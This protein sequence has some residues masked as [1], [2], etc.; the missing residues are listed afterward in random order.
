MAAYG[1]RAT[2]NVF[3]ACGLSAATIVALTVLTV[4]KAV[5]GAVWAYLKR[6]GSFFLT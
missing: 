3:I 5:K 2:K 1:R 6:C 4:N